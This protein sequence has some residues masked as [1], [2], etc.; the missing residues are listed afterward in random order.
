MRRRLAPVRHEPKVKPGGNADDKLLPASAKSTKIG[1]QAAGSETTI[2]GH[3][4]LRPH[5]R[6]PGLK[7]SKRESV[8]DS[9]A[10]LQR[11]A[12]ERAMRRPVEYRGSVSTKFAINTSIGRSLISGLARY[13]KLRSEY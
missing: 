3:S 1:R 9:T 7:K 5:P 6:Y 8:R 10:R 12:R 4:A 13:S 2:D 11:A